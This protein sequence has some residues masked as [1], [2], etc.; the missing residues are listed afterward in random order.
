MNYMKQKGTILVV[1]DSK[2][3]LELISEMLKSD[4][5]K[6]ITAKNGSEAISFLESNRPDLILLDRNMPDMDGIEVCKQIKS[7]KQVSKIPII[8][9]TATK[10]VFAIVEGFKLGAVDY[11]TKPFQKEEL[12]ARANSHINLYRLNQILSKQKSKLREREKTLSEYI[13]EKDKFLSI[14]GHD[15]KG[16]L[17]NIEQLSLLLKSKY[18]NSQNQQVN[19]IIDHLISTSRNTNRLLLNLLE[20]ASYQRGKIEYNPG[21]IDL[22][23]EINS[24]FALLESNAATKEISLYN[25][26]KR[27]L[28]V[29]VD[30]NMLSTILRNLVSNAIK[31]TSRYGKIIVSCKTDVN[32]C[33]VSISDTGIGIAP[34]VMKKLF[35]LSK[36]NTTFGTDGEN[37]TG[38][39]LVL[40]S[41]FVE[42]NGGRIWVE[43]EVGIG[44]NFFF[45][46]PLTK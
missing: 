3:L 43:S 11:I 40:C 9:L 30:K 27:N 12:L 34:E 29:Y 18:G 23:D 46:L 25:E 26:V 15:L 16:P 19:V 39:G 35:S 7:R 37:G 44:S 32:E 24:C 33:Q 38:L 4:G 8:F 6:A 14:I 45:T 2:A 20:W 1:D 13:A 41:E 22:Y 42:R 5:Y 36:S 31:F 21:E 17:S 28:F 10:D